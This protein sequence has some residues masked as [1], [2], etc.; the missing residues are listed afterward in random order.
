MGHETFQV[1]DLTAVIGDNEPAK[2]RVG[3]TQGDVTSL[4]V[5]HSVPD[6]R[7]GANRVPAGDDREPRHTRTSTTSSSMLGGIGSP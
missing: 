6:L 4:L 3:L 1:G 5:I 7:E 2:W